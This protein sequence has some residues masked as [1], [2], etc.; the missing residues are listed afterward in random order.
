MEDLILNKPAAPKTRIV[1]AAQIK[2]CGYKVVAGANG[3]EN[4]ERLL[5]YVTQQGQQVTTPCTNGVY[6]VVKERKFDMYLDHYFFIHYNSDSVVC[7]VEP[8]KNQK[9]AHNMVPE[10]DQNIKMLEVIIEEGGFCSIR[11]VPPKT[12]TADIEQIKRFIDSATKLSVG[13]KIADR[14]SIVSYGRGLEG[15]TLSIDVRPPSKQY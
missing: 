4:Y 8:V 6:R 5:V 2:P 13:E 11:R 9:Y 3:D 15:L 7:R 1:K 12:D 10:D 14:F